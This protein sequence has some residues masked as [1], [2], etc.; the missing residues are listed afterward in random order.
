MGLGGDGV[1]VHQNAYQGGVA[2]SAAMGKTKHPFGIE[3]S[4]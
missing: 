4:L 2:G 1:A 3:K